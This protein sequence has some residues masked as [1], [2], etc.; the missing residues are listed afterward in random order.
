MARPLLARVAAVP[1][2]LARHP[3]VSLAVVT[4]LLLSASWLLKR[5][6][7]RLPA[8]QID[9][10]RYSCA[11]SLRRASPR[12]VDHGSEPRERR[13]RA[14]ALLA[15]LGLLAHPVGANHCVEPL[16]LLYDAVGHTRLVEPH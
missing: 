13:A 9:L 10:Y 14:D 7:V 1:D 15:A 8:R 3:Y 4:G 5:A 12:P 2:S 16:Q 11:P 6:R